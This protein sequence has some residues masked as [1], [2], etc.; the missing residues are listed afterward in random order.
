MITA[1]REFLSGAWLKAAGALV[2]LAMAAG[3]LLAVR[4]GGRDA[5]R[6][7]DATRALDRT[8]DANAARE[9]ASRPVTQEEEAVDEF[10]RDRAR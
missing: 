7:E 2:A 3:V 1:A 6:A 10:N 9:Q 8:Q 5:Q 4:K